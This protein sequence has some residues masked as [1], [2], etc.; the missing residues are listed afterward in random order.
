MK[1]LG[2]DSWPLGGTVEPKSVPVRNDAIETN[3]RIQTSATLSTGE[4]VNL[5][6]RQ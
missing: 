4:Q 1:T 5:P 6:D 3:L 2:K